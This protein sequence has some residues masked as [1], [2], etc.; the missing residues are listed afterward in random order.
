[1]AYAPKTPQQMPV[2]DWIR[3]PLSESVRERLADPP[4]AMNSM[5][6][7]AGMTKLVDQHVAGQIDYGWKLIS[8]LTLAEW[9]EQLPWRS[10]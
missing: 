6:D 5:F 9:F 8:L 7:P 3:G 1:M 2:N 4:E 10:S